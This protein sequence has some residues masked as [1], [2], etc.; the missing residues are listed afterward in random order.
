MLDQEDEDVD[1]LTVDVEQLQREGGLN[2][3]QFRMPVLLDINES[4]SEEEM[5]AIGAG[6]FRRKSTNHE[7]TELM[8]DAV[9]GH[10]EV[11]DG[12]AGAKR[13]RGD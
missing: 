2:G 5:V 3:K 1:V 11:A 8:E 13:R 6:Q 4:D 9:N 7:E 10:G 12:A